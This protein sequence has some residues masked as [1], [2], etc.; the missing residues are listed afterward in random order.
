VPAFAVFACRSEVTVMSLKDEDQNKVHKFKI[1][2]EH[3]DELKTIA[4]A[5]GITVEEAIEEAFDQW[6]KKNL[7]KPN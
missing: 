5:R 1:K 2:A 4:D 7:R 3:L 6:L